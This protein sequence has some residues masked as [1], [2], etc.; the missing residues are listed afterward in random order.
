MDTLTAFDPRPLRRISHVEVGSTSQRVVLVCGHAF[1]APLGLDY[2][3][4]T[5]A[6]CRR[7]ALIAAPLRSVKMED[8]PGP[9]RSRSPSYG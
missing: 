7:C 6:R 2:T 9:P 5:E 4:E 8:G 3:C 1:S